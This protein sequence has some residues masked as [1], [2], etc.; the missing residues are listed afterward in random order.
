VN[1]VA[2]EYIFLLYVDILLSKISTPML[3]NHMSSRAG[4]TGPLATSLSK[5]SILRH[6]RNKKESSVVEDVITL[7]AAVRAWI[8]Y[9]F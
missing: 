5:N 1:S 3:F 9:V 8:F 2:P 7:P 4:T 6:F